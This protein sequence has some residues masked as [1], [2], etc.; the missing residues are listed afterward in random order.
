MSLV[1]APKQLVLVR[2]FFF[3]FP[4]ALEV[5]PLLVPLGCGLPAAQLGQVNLGG[6]S[7]A[8]R[9]SARGLSPS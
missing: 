6:D 5:D 2:V 9:Q 7:G 1:D 3:K 4:E 8:E